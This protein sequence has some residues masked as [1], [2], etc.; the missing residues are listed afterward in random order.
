GRGRLRST[1]G[2]GLVP[3]E[4]E[5]RTSSEIREATAD[6]AKRV[7][8]SDPD[9]ACKYL[10]IEEYRCL[11][12]AQAEIETEEAATK[13]F[14][15]NDEWR[16]CQWDQYKFNEGLTYIEGPQIRKAYRFAPNYKYA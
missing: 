8:Q 15:W 10:A 11:L 3:S 12:T 13:C 9:D 5:P 4:A 7:H 2:I 14:K 16:R 1:Y 6:Y